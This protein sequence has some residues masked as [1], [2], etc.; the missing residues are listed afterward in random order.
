MITVQLNGR[1]GNNMFQI[2]A[3]LAVGKRNNVDSFYIGDDSHIKGFKLK[4]IQ[5]G[6]KKSDFIFE[7]RKFNFDD[8]FYSLGDRTHLIGYFQSE[9]NFI[10]AEDE[11]RKCFSFTQSVVDETLRS[12]NGRYKKFFSGERATA[13]HVRRTDYL[14]YPDIYPEL[15]ADYYRKSLE[16]IKDKGSILIFS[17]DYQWCK[18]NFNDKGFELVDMSPMSSMY[19]MS[20]CSNIIMANSTFSWWAAW[21][22]KPEMTIYP[23]KWFGTKWPHQNVHTTLEDCVKDITPTNWIGI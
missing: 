13:V 12:N 22:G 5:K 20:N 9:K 18:N 23:K 11:V 15:N 2:A 8:S 16:M 6:I 17:D 1:T 7:E 14:K 3:A 10:R 4:G 19:L 21:L